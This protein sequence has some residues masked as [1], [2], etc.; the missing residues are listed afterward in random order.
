MRPS[1]VITPDVRP[2]L[3]PVFHEAFIRSYRLPSPW[4]G[5]DIGEYVTSGFIRHDPLPRI[6]GCIRPPLMDAL[7]Q[8][9]VRLGEYFARCQIRNWRVEL[10]GSVSSAQR[11]MTGQ[12]IFLVEVLSSRQIPFTCF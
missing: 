8:P 3:K 5:E 2:K 1:V 10:H 6:H 11:T 9:G 12:A 7:Q 4:K